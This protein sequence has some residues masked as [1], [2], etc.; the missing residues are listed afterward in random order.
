MKDSVAFQLCPREIQTAGDV[1]KECHEKA[2]SMPIGN[3][4]EDYAW[5]I[6]SE[7][8]N[9]EWMRLTGVDWMRGDEKCEGASKSW[10]DLYEKVI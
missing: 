6:G 7:G 9:T 5:S 3:A 4:W 2:T 1:A 8:M 10:M